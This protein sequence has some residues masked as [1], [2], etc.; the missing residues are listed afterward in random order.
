[1]ATTNQ[2]LKAWSRAVGHLG[3]GVDLFG[4]PFEL[5]LRHR[6]RRQGQP[7]P[8][9]LGLVQGAEAGQDP[10]RQQLRKARHH[11]FLGHPPSAVAP[12]AK[13]RSHDAVLEPVH[14]GTVEGVQDGEGWRSAHATPPTVRRR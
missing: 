9:T 6:H 14:Q 12:S 2:R 1:V 7:A 4:D 8:E 5:R 3:E 13:G 11:L 10:A